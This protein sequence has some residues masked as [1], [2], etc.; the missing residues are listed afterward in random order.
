MMSSEVQIANLLY[1][2]A[3]CIDTGNIEG[4]A[5]LF[6][7]ATVKIREGERTADEILEI[8]REFLI[9]YENGTPRTKHV[10]TNPIIEVDEA[11]GKATCRSYYVVFQ[12]FDG[13]VHP[14][15]AGRYHDWF[16]RHDGVWRYSYRD[17]SL[18]DHLGDMSHHGH[19]P[20]QYA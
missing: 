13:K 10:I 7:N 9:I 4:A 5:D 18:M 6:R 11:A 1:R 14:I 15:V 20:E 12:D 19:N 2:Y 3:E 8:W 16:E 17:Y